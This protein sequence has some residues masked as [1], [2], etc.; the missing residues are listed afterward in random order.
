MDDNEDIPIGYALHIHS[1]EN[2]GDCRKTTSFFGLTEED[3]R[4]YLD[5]ASMFINMHDR[6]KPGFGGGG[7]HYKD[8]ARFLPDVHDAVDAAIARHPKVSYKVKERFKLDRCVGY[9]DIYM[10]LIIDLVGYPEDTYP[11]DYIRCFDGADVYYH[12][13]AVPNVSDKFDGCKTGTPY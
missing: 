3:V 4:L 13:T 5:V 6:F 1:W 2:D 12:E 7:W 11:G 10:E 9:E 8:A